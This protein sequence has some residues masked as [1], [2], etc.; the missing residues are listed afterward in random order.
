MSDWD[1]LLD[2]K[3][4]CNTWQ[5]QTYLLYLLANSTLNEYER[6]IMS[7]AI[8]DPDLTPEYAREIADYL[9]INQLHFSNIP[10]PSQT[11]ISRFVD[12]IS[13]NLK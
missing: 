10:N 6:D 12:L 9:R 1:E 5:E 11:Q 13:K 7:D 3:P 8:I 4:K 2:G